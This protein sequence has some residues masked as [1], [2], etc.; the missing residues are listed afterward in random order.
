MK[1]E[2]WSRSRKRGALI[3][4]CNPQTLF[5]VDAIQ[6]YGKMR[7]YPAKMHVDLLSVS[8][9]KIHNRKEADFYMTS[10]H[11]IS[12]ERHP[13]SVEAEGILFRSFGESSPFFGKVFVFTGTLD[14]RCHGCH[15][16]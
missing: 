2:R 14:K 11:S 12:L 13:Q 3:K 4:Q 16:S 5:H 10:R 1:S 8:G 7:I 15:V 6:S 9:H